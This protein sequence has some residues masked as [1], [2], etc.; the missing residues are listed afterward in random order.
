MANLQIRRVGN[1]HYSI[2]LAI[3]V[4]VWGQ[5]SVIG[6]PKITV[7]VTNELPNENPLTIHCRS[8][9]DDLGEHTLAES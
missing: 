4:F 7:V 9:D 3:L 8:K 5:K 1:S 2:L 6:D